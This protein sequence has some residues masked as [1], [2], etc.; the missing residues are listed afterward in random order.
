MTNKKFYL[1]HWF[2]PLLSIL[3]WVG[4]WWLIAWRFAKPLILP[5]PV[6]VLHRLGEL[7][8]TAPFWIAVA[9]SLVRILLGILLALAFG[10]LLAWLT[11]KSRACHHLFSPL[12]ALFKATPVA[13]VIFLMLLWVGRD[14]VP[15]LIAFMMA[16]PIVWSNLREGLLQT[17]R[18]LLEMAQIFAFSTAKRIRF[19]HIPSLTPY[20]LSACRSAISLAWKAGVAAEVLCVPQ[21]SL[22]R[23]IWEGKQYLLTDD[24]FAYTLT[25][26]LLSVAIEAGT[27]AL[28]RRGQR[29]ERK[30]EKSDAATA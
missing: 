25:V 26:I 15:L 3:F 12:L 6:A 29:H 16:L 20:F 7:L 10:A 2:F 28:L 4:L 27:L 22:G 5:T 1:P 24:L 11:V 19:I 23:A 8:A 18:G 14:R 9:T 13:S 30:E 17:D 21:R